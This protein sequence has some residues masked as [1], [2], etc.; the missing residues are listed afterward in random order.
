MSKCRRATRRA[1]E[2]RC[3]SSYA[4]R[5]G[6]QVAEPSLTE[7]VELARAGDQE[8]WRTLVARVKNLVWKVVSGFRLPR[9]DAEDAFAATFFRLAE[10]IDTIRD[11]ER[12]AGWVATTARNESLAI[13]K[14]NRRVLTVDPTDTWTPGDHAERLVDSELKHAIHESFKLLSEACQQLLRLLTADP[15][16]SYEDIAVVLDIPMGSIGPN[17][18]RCLERLRSNRPMRPFMTETHT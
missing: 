18:Q 6:P 3:K 4:P 11:P 9:A 17:R 5:V 2:R 7:L 12:L 16:T 8:A 14:R 13:L 15:P 10:H 1:I